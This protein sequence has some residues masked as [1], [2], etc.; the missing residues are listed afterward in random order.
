[1]MSG[2][3][4]VRQGRESIFGFKEKREIAS[5]IFLIISEN[6]ECQ[7]ERIQNSG[8]C[9]TGNGKSDKGCNEETRLG[10]LFSRENS[11][12]INE[13]AEEEEYAID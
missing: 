1:M 6:A 4:D 7:K 2:Q 9:C 8:S 5:G 10:P 11:R 12:G 3:W 13:Q